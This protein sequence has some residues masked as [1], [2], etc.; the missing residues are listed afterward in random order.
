MIT[1]LLVRLTLLLP[2]QIPVLCYHQIRD[3]RPTD[4]RVN[5][6]YIMPPA[7]F[8]ARMKMLAD[9]GYHTIQ[10]DELYAH[11]TKG[12]PLPAKPIMITFDD[13]DADQYNIA[14]PELAK[15]G[16]KGVYFI[17]FNNINK[18]KYYMTRAQIRQLADEGNT[19]SCHTLDHPSLAKVKPADLAAQL[20]T[21]KQKLELLTGRPVK[22]LAYP[23]GVWNKRLL[24][25]VQRFG[26][27]AAFSL[28]QPRDPQY[29]LMTIRRIIDN[30]GGSQ[31]RFDY[32]I[33]H[34][35][36]KRQ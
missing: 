19:I 11:L 4:R 1:S 12:T 9:S 10:P 35:F 33:K 8:R 34:G 27:T 31:A 15:Y 29:P 28:D 21:P 24:P 26:Y 13:T 5:K 6:E 14:R 22:Y 25:E 23:F 7:T 17:T 3:W 20:E 2:P 30:G 32:L 16:F 18:N 36:G